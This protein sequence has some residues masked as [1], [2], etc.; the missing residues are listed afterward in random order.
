LKTKILVTAVTIVLAIYS[1]GILKESLFPRDPSF[2]PIPASTPITAPEPSLALE[3]IP[4]PEP[5]SPPEIIPASEPTPASEPI[6]DYKKIPVGTLAS[7]DEMESAP[8]CEFQWKGLPA[9]DQNLWTVLGPLSSSLI[10]VF[11]SLMIE[12]L[13]RHIC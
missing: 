9:D 10:C 5:I 11:V 7:A 12:F 4:G 8:S 1:G 3:L 2:V 13:I 6:S